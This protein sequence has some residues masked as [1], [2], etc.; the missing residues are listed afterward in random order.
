MRPSALV[1]IA[2]VSSRHWR[3]D[4]LV[5]W[6]NWCIGAIGALV[7]WCV[8]ALVRWCVGALVQAVEAHQHERQRLAPHVRAA[9]EDG[10]VG[11]VGH[12][13][14][15]RL[16]RL[17]RVRVRGRGR[18]R[19]RVRVRACHR[20]YGRSKCSHGEHSNSSK[21]RRLERALLSTGPRR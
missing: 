13:V 12:A 4:A 15:E 19:V 8:G 16:R 3:I 1:S 6:C 20:E 2:T 21:C 10:G 14:E 7:R 5:H 9:Q 17:V 11:D 18:V